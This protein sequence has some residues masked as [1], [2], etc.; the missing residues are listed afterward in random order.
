M[1]PPSQLSIATSSVLR[2]LK[3]EAS[4][5]TELEGQK[6]RLQ[7]LETESDD[8]EEGNR[9]WNIGQEKRAMKE[10][11]AVFAP[12]K[13]KVVT[14]VEALESLLLASEEGRGDGGGEDEIVKARNAVEKSKNVT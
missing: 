4:Y 9:A 11:E 1:A 14:A 12:L 13:E 8:D 2:L 7:T 6:K 5:R 10:T 3:E